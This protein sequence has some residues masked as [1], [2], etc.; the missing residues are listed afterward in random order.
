MAQQ[1]QQ[2]QQLAILNAAANKEN[3]NY[4]V[5]LLMELSN[6][7]IPHYIIPLNSV[8]MSMAFTRYGCEPVRTTITVHGLIGK[9]TFG[10]VYRAR[11]D[12]S[13]RW[14]ALKQVFLD[15]Y[16][17]EREV[18]IMNHMPSHC[19]IM[20]LILFCY[21][22]LGNPAHTYMLMAMDFMPMSLLDFIFEHRLRGVPL[23]YVRI[24]SYQMFRAL[25]YL[26]SH[27]ICHRDVKPENLLLNPQTMNLRLSDFGSAKFIN[28]QEP[29]ET[30]V[31]SRLYRAPELFA[32][33]AIYGTRVDI[34]SAG[35]VLAELL[36]GTPLFSSN[37]LGDSQ[38]TYIVYLLGTAGLERVPQISAA[39][40]IGANIYLPR[41]SWRTLLGVWAPADLLQ[42]LDDCLVYDPAA[43]ISPLAACAHS[44]YDELRTMEALQTSMPSGAM[45][46]P[47]FNFSAHELEVDP[48]L[49]LHLLPL[50]ILPETTNSA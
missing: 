12:N 47:L 24:L 45:L 29:N 23:I 38:L 30:Y 28:P 48:G 1:E 31:C 22:K 46:P 50:Q 13:E 49:W 9:G 5:P 33:C 16:Y 39:S 8:F 44:S 34:W 17:M 42:L 40:G 6:V 4:V 10:R 19:N 25:A 18:E 21:A 36:K 32:K 26:H 35:C 2:Q 43:R 37:R 20:Q 3:E 14:V 15:S 41:T 7:N 11:L 27:F